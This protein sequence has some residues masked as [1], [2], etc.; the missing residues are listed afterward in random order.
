[1]RRK[2]VQRARRRPR[3]P[4]GIKNYMEDVRSCDNRLGSNRHARN[5]LPVLADLG[6]PASSMAAII[7]CPVSLIGE[8]YRENAIL[9]LAIYELL[10]SVAVDLVECAT[11]KH[12]RL[13]ELHNCKCESCTAYKAGRRVPDLY[14]AFLEHC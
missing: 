8:W 10:L 11:E 4:R 6:C 14:D 13:Q 2:D 7:R 12:T 1:M 5:I 3:R 9:P